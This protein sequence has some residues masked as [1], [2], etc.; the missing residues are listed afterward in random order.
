MILKNFWAHRRQN[1]FIFVEIALI[2]VLSFWLLD[3]IVVWAYDSYFCH[4]DGEFEKEHLLV[5]QTARLTPITSPTPDPSRG[6]EGSEY[7]QAGDTSEELTTP[8]PTAGG[9]RRGADLLAP[10]LDF[11]DKVRSLPEVQSVCL[12]HDLVGDG[13]GGWNSRALAPE[14][15]TTRTCSSYSKSFVVGHCYFETVGITALAG[16]PS[17]E[18]L[19]RD[20]PTDGVVITRS[21]AVQLFGT[22]EAV[23]RRMVE[24]AYKPGPDSRDVEGI[25]HYTVYGVVEDVKPA[26]HERH[27]YVAFFPVN[28]FSGNTPKMLIRLKPDADATEFIAKNGK[29]ATDTYAFAALSTYDD[30]LTKST[31]LSDQTIIVTLLSTLGLLFALNVVLGT[32]GTFWL[33]IRKRT[34]DIGIM[35][36]FGAKRRHLFWMI[37]GEGALLTLLACIVGQI[38]WLQ[39]AINIGLTD[40]N[41]RATSLREGDWVDTFWLHYLV[42]CVVQYLLLLA[43]VTL[44]IVVPTF[45]AMYKRPVDALRHE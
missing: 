25:S 20:I 18:T 34:E 36:S 5:G 4:A 11:R 8:L 22:A 30:F 1:G 24:I 31:N 14:A 19:S 28:L 15:D 3:H 33:Q 37:W 35:R 26:P 6:G 12:T 29:M 13:L 45:R 39:F 40:G 43:I 10:L 21:L 42:V 17:A 27:F 2:A 9:D 44:G 7:S 38:I 32:L 23:G 16:N 41:I